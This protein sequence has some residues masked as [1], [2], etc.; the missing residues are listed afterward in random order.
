MRGKDFLDKMELADPSFVE[1]ADKPKKKKLRAVK[2][3]ALAACLTLTIFA[4]IKLIPQKE[5]QEEPPQISPDLPVLSISSS[6]SQGAGTGD[7]LLR[8]VSELDDENPWNEEVTLYTLPVYKNPLEYE[9]CYDFYYAANSDYDKMREVLFE[10]AT[11]LGLDPETLT[12]TDNTTNE[13]DIE[14][15]LDTAERIGVAD[16][17]DYLEKRLTPTTFYGKAEGVEITVFNDLQVKIE[18][19]PPL[20]LPD[21][22]DLSANADR[23]DISSA[24]KYIKRE[25]SELIGCVD[26]AIN[27]RQAGYDVNIKAIYDCFFFENEGSLTDR[28]VNYNF[29]QSSFHGDEKGELWLIWIDQPDLS[30][31]VGDYPIISVAEATELLYNGNYV[32]PSFHEITGEDTVAMVSLTYRK[33]MYDEY[34][35]PYYCFYVE[36]P[37]DIVWAEEN[38]LKTYGTFYVPA[39]ESTYIADM[40]L[41]NGGMNQ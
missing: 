37:T 6:L 41:W 19:D 22:Y 20:S 28:I 9:T 13:K 35:I 18:F 17:D 5:P 11:V 40:P 29:F 21:K 1:A 36:V 30:N 33:G 4:G 2:W 16:I 3:S 8:D 32:T 39:I 7:I 25:Y 12:V 14:K 23:R 38:G 26:P 10:T 24:M 31:K 34:F 27:I 15:L